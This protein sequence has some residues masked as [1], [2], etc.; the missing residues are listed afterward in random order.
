MSLSEGMVEQ[1]MIHPHYGI[2]LSNK[3]AQTTDTASWMNLQGIMPIGKGQYKG[4]I[5]ISGSQATGM[6]EGWNR[7]RVGIKG[8]Q[9][10]CGDRKFLYLD[11][12]NVN[13]NSEHRTLVLQDAIIGGIHIISLHFFHTIAC[14]STITQI[15][16]LI[17]K[18]HYY[19]F[20][21]CCAS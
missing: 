10:N 16:N 4:Y 13:L 14:E 2:L 15:K 7:K 19:I 11:W 18:T 6:E 20:W 17:F 5:Q 3:K 1:I 12:I 8:Q 21:L 9:R